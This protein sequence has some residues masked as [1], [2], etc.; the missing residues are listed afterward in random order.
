MQEPELITISLDG[1]CA[2]VTGAGNGMG[3]VVTFPFVAAGAD[4]GI[5]DSLADVC[6]RSQNKY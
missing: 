4:L 6:A 2:I 3:R 1:E 5:S